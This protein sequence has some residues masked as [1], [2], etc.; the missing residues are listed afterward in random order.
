MKTREP[1]KYMSI[2]IVDP[3]KGGEPAFAVRVQP[4]LSDHVLAVGPR[5]QIEDVKCNVGANLGENTSGVLRMWFLYYTSFTYNCLNNK[6]VPYNSTW[7]KC[8]HEGSV[9]NW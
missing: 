5:Y 1:R 8:R 2:D 4:D 6:C 3:E 7:T 9:P